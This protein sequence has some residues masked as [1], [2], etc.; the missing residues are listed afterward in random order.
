[1]VKGAGVRQGG[2][3]QN[4]GLRG[5]NGGVGEGFINTPLIQ[6]RVGPDIPIFIVSIDFLLYRCSLL[7]YTAYILSGL[8]L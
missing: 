2:L 7:E 1:M 3:G 4:R 8:Y 6:V 5:L